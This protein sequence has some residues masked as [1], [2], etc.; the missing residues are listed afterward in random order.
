[1][2][3]IEEL[4]ASCRKWA[5]RENEV[6]AI[7]ALT[8]LT[9][10]YMSQCGVSLGMRSFIHEIGEHWTYKL[11]LTDHPLS[12]LANQYPFIALMPFL[13]QEFAN[14][15]EHYLKYGI[16]RLS[17]NIMVSCGLDVMTDK[18]MD[19]KLRIAI[20]CGFIT[21]YNEYED[22]KSIYGKGDLPSNQP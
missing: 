11:S 2:D 13:S 20:A 3:N 12:E 22:F 8:R 18:S 16:T 15:A 7:E 21:Y 6:T 9:E 4:L 1:M 5:E 10:F 19:E 17:E 14:R